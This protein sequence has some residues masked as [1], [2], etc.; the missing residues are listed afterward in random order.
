MP[1]FVIVRH[2]QSQWNAENRFTGNTDT[3]LTDLGR[4]EA[5]EA[6]RLLKSHQPPDF[7]IGFTSVL[8]RAIETMSIILDEIGQADLPIERSAALNERMYG[9]LQ[10]MNKTEAEERFG[11]DQVFCWRRSYTARPPHGETLEETRTRVVAYFRSTILP[12]LKANESVLVVAHGNSLRALL[13]E[14]EHISPEDIE[15]VE[16]ATGVPRQY[17]YDIETGEFQLLPK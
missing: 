1:L 2:G 10:G 8:Q 9:D 3:P 6:G 17:H 7:S 14:L 11:A 4:H 15:K 13:M 16:L 12:H 5:H